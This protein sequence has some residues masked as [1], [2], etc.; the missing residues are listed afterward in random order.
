MRGAA[1]G[2]A[3]AGAAA[4]FTAFDAVGR[5][6]LSCYLCQSLVWGFVFYSYGLGLFGRLAS[7]VTAPLGLALYAAQL[8]GSRLWLPTSWSGGVAVARG[9]VRPTSRA[10]STETA[11]GLRTLR[12]QTQALASP[13][14]PSRGIPKLRRVEAMESRVASAPKPHRTSAR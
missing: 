7:A 8:G 14:R 10:A 5:M 9:D 2:A 11:G 12:P 4:D 13:L 6:A 3:T 1:L